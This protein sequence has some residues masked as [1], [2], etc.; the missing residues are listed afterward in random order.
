MVLFLFSQVGSCISASHMRFQPSHMVV[1]LVKAYEHCHLVVISKAPNN[2]NLH[3]R[4]DHYVNMV[5]PWSVFFFSLFKIAGVS[6]QVTFVWRRMCGHLTSKL[7]VKQPHTSSWLRT[8]L[9]RQLQ[10]GKP[11]FTGHHICQ[12]RRK[13][14]GFPSLARPLWKLLWNWSAVF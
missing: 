8:Y 2:T 12:Q 6:K 7:W 9:W 14:A 1:C 13:A 3:L 10:G 11:V 4:K 5:A